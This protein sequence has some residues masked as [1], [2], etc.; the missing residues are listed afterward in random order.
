MTL[1]PGSLKGLANAIIDERIRQ[2]VRRETG[3]DTLPVTVRCL[4]CPD[5]TFTGHPDLSINQQRNHVADQH[6]AK[7]VRK[8]SRSVLHR[9]P[10]GERA[11]QA[12]AR[13]N[14]TAAAGR[15]TKARGQASA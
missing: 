9:G 6:N 3:A 2:I 11:D 14:A 1:D 12:R 5:W 7:T 15:R 10:V 8:R 13:G 4:H